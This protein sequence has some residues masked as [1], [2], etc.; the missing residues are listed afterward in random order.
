MNTRE[1]NSM[2]IRE[3]GL[4]LSDLQRIYEKSSMS[5]YGDSLKYYTANGVKQIPFASNKTI[6][7]YM[8]SQAKLKR[9]TFANLA[10]TTNISRLQ[11]S[12]R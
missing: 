10:R 9:N 4:A 6:Q 1:I 2:L 11:K 7:S 8:T 3:T 5:A 12:S